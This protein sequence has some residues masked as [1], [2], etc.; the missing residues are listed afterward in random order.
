VAAIQAGVVIFHATLAAL[1][2][3][4]AVFVYRAGGRLDHGFAC[5]HDLW[6]SAWFAGHDQ[7][8]HAVIHLC[9]Q[10]RAFRR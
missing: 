6:V 4:R 1:G 8:P 10:K 7:A 3:I 9:E 5:P 2:T